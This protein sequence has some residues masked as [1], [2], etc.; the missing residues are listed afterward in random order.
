MNQFSEK[1]RK[2]NNVGRSRTFQLNHPKVKP[3][4]KVSFFPKRFFKKFCRTIFFKFT[5]CLQN[6]VIVYQ[7]STFY[8][9]TMSNLSYSKF[10]NKKVRT[11]FSRKLCTK[12]IFQNLL[13]FGVVFFS[14]LYSTKKMAN[15]KFTSVYNFFLSKTNIR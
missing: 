2:I 14:Y 6:T 15:L 8:I 13:K 12:F 4:C 1:I 5:F 10:W 11:L 9:I 7:Y 3:T